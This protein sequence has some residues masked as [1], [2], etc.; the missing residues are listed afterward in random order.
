MRTWFVGKESGKLV[1][2]ATATIVDKLTALFCL[3]AVA[4]AAF[5]VERGAVPSSVVRVFV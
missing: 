4:W 1:R 2:A 3:Y 5:A